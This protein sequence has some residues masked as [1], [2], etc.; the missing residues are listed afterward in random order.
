M[1][2]NLAWDALLSKVLTWH[3]VAT[4]IHPRRWLLTSEND[5]GSWYVPTLADWSGLL[6]SIYCWRGRAGLRRRFRSPLRV[7]SINLPKPW[8]G[9]ECAK[10]R[11]M[12]FDRFE[13]SPMEYF[14][15]PDIL[16]LRTFCPQTLYLRT[17]CLGTVYRSLLWLAEPWLV[18]AVTESEVKEYLLLVHFRS[19]IW[20]LIWLKL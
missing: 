3:E 20:W 12:W 13:L 9:V 14:V 4:S 15:P 16:S 1:V 11:R 8:R 17:F 5:P 7:K 6:W 10:L 2:Q 18:P 19:E